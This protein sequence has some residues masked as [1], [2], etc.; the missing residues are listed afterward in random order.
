M[1]LLILPVQAM[2]APASFPEP[3]AL[4]YKINWKGFQVAS[5]I[6]GWEVIGGKQA[7]TNVAVRTYGLANS[8]TQYKSDSV[9]L[10]GINDQDNFIAKRFKTFFS[11]RKSKREIILQWDS[12]GF[13]ANEHN[14]PPEK[15]G[16]RTAVA[17]EQKANAYDPLSAFFVARQKVM[18]GEKKFTLPMYDGRRRSEL[19]FEVLGNKGSQIHIVVKEIFLAGYTKREQEERKTRDIRMHI[20]VDPTD[21]LPTGGFGESLIGTA[22]GKLKAKCKSFDECLTKAEKD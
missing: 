15:P 5:V 4:Y 21:Y 16:K 1:A 12:K 13:I 6:V 22:E 9:S 8:A 10:T 14:E 19:Q 7:L 20:Y 11:Y 2:A 17:P 18:E 3:Q